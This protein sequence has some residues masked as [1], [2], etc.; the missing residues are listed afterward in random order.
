MAPGSPSWAVLG[1]SWDVVLP[2][3]TPFFFASF[4]RCLFES[5]FGRF[6]FPTW[7]PKSSKIDQKSMPRCLPMLTLI[8]DRV[9]IDF[10]SQLRST[11]GAFKIIFFTIE[12]QSFFKKSP[13]EDNIDF[14]SNFGGN[15]APFCF[16]NPLK[17]LKNPILRGIK[18][19]IVF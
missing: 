2:I 10:C 4:F 13:L 14:C 1:P 15:M 5:I 17:S 19:L 12:R 9:L 3:L 11:P 7:F 8:F 16:Q 18:I 6:C